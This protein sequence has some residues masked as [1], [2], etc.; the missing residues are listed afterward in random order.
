[1]E[2]VP[3]CVWPS[4]CIAAV[5]L[6]DEAYARTGTNAPGEAVLNVHER[7]SPGALTASKNSGAAPL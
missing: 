2:P 1:M 4:T 5:E 6:T 3:V 7:V